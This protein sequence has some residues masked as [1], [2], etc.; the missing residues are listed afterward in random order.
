MDI[1]FLLLFSHALGDF[2]FQSEYMV[3]Q[4]QPQKNKDSWY[5]F[6]LSHSVIH[7]GLIGFFTGSFL[8]AMLETVCHFV[9]DYGKMQGKYDIQIDQLLHVICKALWVLLIINGI[10]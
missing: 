4:K 7:G 2:A 10:A 6:L 1:F 5:I 8:L 3:K 9:I